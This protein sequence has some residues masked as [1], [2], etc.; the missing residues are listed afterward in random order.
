MSKKEIPNKES[1]VYGKIGDGCSKMVCTLDTAETGRENV[2]NLEILD[3]KKV[4]LTEED[5]RS[6][7][8]IEW[9]P[10]VQEWLYVYADPDFQK[11]LRDYQEFFRKLPENE[12]ADI[13][14][15]KCDGLTVGFL[16]LWRLGAFMEHVASIGV[17][18]HPDYWRKGIARQ[19]I[20]SAI[21]L[22]RDKGIKRL[23]V[24][25]LV[26]NASMRHLAERLGFKL[27]SL[28]KERI[29][30]GG[31]YHDEASYFMLL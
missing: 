24:E 23:E 4:F 11:E 14:I 15:A 25:T 10:K 27:E 29:K 9:H 30:K 5:V 1:C 28:R 18:V 6:I 8:E 22:A 13:L 12:K 20:Q 16:A 17:S 2:L 21:E 31:L 3:V 26:E 19:L 7:A